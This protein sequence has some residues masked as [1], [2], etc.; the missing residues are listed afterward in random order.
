[1]YICYLTLEVHTIM[2]SVVVKKHQFYAV[3]TFY[4]IL[5]ISNFKMLCVLMS[6]IT[7]LIYNHYKSAKN[8]TF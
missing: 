2:I 1:M 4:T 3:T 8:E 6:T 5:M 7:M